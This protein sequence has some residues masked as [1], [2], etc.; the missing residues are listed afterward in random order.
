[1]FPG[2]TIYLR[3]H[4]RSSWYRHNYSKN[5]LKEICEKIKEA[6]PSK[7]YVFFNNNHNMLN[8]ARAMLEIL[9]IRTQL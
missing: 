8:N 4:G 5:E 3:M 7:V 2:K 1:V 9:R 6:R